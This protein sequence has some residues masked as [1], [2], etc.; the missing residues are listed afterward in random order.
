MEVSN[1]FKVNTSN[2]DIGFD[3]QMRKNTQYLVTYLK[4]LVEN[5]YIS[6]HHFYLESK[7][8]YMKVFQ[9]RWQELT[10]VAMTYT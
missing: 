8:I 6:T 3:N 9:P 1:I 5:Q 10:W 2:I 7:M 4:R